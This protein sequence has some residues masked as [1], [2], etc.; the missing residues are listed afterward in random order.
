MAADLSPKVFLGDIVMPIQHYSLCLLLSS[1]Q[2]L[3]LDYFELSLLLSYTA[4]RGFDFFID[5]ESY[6]SHL[7]EQV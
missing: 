3:Y 4:M 2:M 7:A 6:L 5:V 1:A